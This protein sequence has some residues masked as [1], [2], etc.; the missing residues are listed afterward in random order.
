MGG[1][2]PTTREY[3]SRCDQFS[4]SCVPPP[5]GMHSSVGAM[6]VVSLNSGLDPHSSLGPYGPWTFLILTSRVVSMRFSWLDQGPCHVSSCVST[7]SVVSGA[8]LFPNKCLLNE[9]FS[10]E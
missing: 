2:K 10:G 6:L 1:E 5:Q 4:G 8:F 3:I 7:L 9:C